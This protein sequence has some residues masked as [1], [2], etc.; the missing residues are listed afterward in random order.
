MGQFQSK[1]QSYDAKDNTI[2]NNGSLVTFNSNSPEPDVDELE[3]K[4]LKESWVL[5]QGSIS[6]V[7]IITF[8]K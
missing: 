1:N 7:G 5:I 6:K 8:L 2:K 4:L 3:V